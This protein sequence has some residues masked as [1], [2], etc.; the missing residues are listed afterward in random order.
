MYA[1]RTTRAMGDAQRPKR[2]LEPYVGARAGRMRRARSRDD[3][4]DAEDDASFG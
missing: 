4:D 1:T 3:A 2:D